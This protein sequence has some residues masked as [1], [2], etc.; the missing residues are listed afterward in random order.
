MSAATAVLKTADRYI[1]GSNTGT[2][3]EELQIN[4]SDTGVF[5]SD[6]QAIYGALGSDD[7]T[8]S[9]T[10]GDHYLETPAAARNDVA[11][12]VVGW[13]RAHI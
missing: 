12:L 3:P 11:D 1:S 7:K 2:A 10:P 13:L 8:L 6:A 9:M 4:T 5:P